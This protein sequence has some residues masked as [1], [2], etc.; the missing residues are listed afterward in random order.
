[1]VWIDVPVDGLLFPTVQSI[2]IEG[3]A[4]SPEGIASIEI[5]IDG[6]LLTEI[7]DPPMEGTIAHF[8]IS[9]T[10]SSEGTYMIQAVATSKDGALSEMDRTT[11]TFGGDTPTLV[12][13]D[14]PTPVSDGQVQ[15]YADPPEIS[16]GDCVD[17]FWNA[18][19][20]QTVIF[21]GLEQ[22]HSGS[23]HACLCET[24]RYTLTVTHLDDSEEQFR[25]EVPVTGSCITPTV[26]DVTPPPAPTLVVPESGLTLSCRSSQT[27]TWLPVDD[28]SGIDY[29][30]VEAQTHSGD[31]NWSPIGGS[32]FTVYDK[33]TNVPVD[34]GWYYRWRVR[35]VDGAGN[36][37]SW[38]GWSTFTITLE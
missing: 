34:C 37:G 1:M 20:V 29:Y 26:E 27:L 2:N 6:V 22:P 18:E 14:T 13:T 5:W 36:V 17:L 12:I 33:T 15:F 25:V 35:A 30:Q 11:V 21:G 24:T 16:A 10:P 8:E 31:N 23:Y 38:S 4:A 32:P 9:W 3:H 7:S 28:E 19:E